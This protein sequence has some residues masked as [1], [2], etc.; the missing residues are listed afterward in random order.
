MRTV[1]TKL[2]G[3][4]HDY[5]GH[6]VRAMTHVAAAIRHL[7]PTA[8]LNTNVAAGQGNLPQAQSD[9]ILRDALVHLNTAETSLG[10]GTNAATH[11]H[12]ARTSVA[13]AIHELNTALTIR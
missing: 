7:H 8:A 2:R 10:S 5:Q 3:A 9:Q 6:R 4:D 12:S 11:H 1:H 13:E